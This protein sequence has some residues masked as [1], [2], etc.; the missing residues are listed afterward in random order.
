LDLVLTL[1]QLLDTAGGGK[2]AREEVGRR[3][4]CPRVYRKHTEK[5]GKRGDLG[6]SWIRWI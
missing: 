1:L 3:D 4:M 5:H 2:G 6:M